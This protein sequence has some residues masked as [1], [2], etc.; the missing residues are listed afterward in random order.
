MDYKRNNLTTQSQYI[1]D[2]F[3]PEDKIL[4]SVKDS[5]INNN[6]K[7]IN[8]NPDEAKIL[9]ILLRLINAKNIVE[10]GTLAAYSTIWLARSLVD[11]GKLY[12][13]EKEEKTAEIAKNNIKNSD[14]SDKVEIIIGDA[15]KNLA[16]IE[17]KSPFDAIFIDAEKS[18]Y[19]DYLDWA[20]KNV[21][22][23]GLII[24]DNSFLF[25]LVYQENPLDKNSKNAE[26]M[27]SFNLR[28]SN[29]EKYDSVII[30]TKEGLTIAIKKF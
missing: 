24:G 6:L 14:V 30:P 12:S 13:F 22:K 28:L 9:Q 29:P 15:H 27:K 26:I 20:E 2:L 17:N 10:I 3:A 5:I 1:S 8:I 25:G 19:C 7:P 18:G 4:I 23:G 21:R 16:L 11:G